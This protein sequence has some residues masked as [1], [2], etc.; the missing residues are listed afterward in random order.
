MKIHPVGA[1]FFPSEQNRRTDGRTDGRTDRETDIY[2]EVSVP[3]SRF[4]KC[5]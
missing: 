2:D 5:P 3:F 4:C 1:E